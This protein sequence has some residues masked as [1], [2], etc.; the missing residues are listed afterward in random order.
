MM[1]SPVVLAA[2]LAIAGLALLSPLP[3]VEDRPAATL[4]VGFGEADVTPKVEPKGKPVYLAGF[5]HNRKATGVNDPL[6]ARAVVFR[7]GK[8]KVAIVSV[9]VVGLF[10]EFVQ[11]VRK[12]LP[13]FTYVVVSSTHNH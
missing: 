5:G 12:H 11:Q 4:E 3:A 10:N 7:D 6:H 1:R 2:S 8:T 9:D 13:D